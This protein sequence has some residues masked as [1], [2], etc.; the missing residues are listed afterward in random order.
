M[1]F[2]LL[3][4]LKQIKFP[5]R[6]LI[7]IIREIEIAP[8]YGVENLMSVWTP[9]HL[10]H[11]LHTQL[12]MVA[13][14]ESNR[15]VKACFEIAGWPVHNNNSRALSHHFQMVGKGDVVKPRCK[16]VYKLCMKS[17]SYPFFNFLHLSEI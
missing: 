1:K 16:S 4:R 9:K 7:Q 10:N 14:A 13:G 15:L 6:V 12:E 3:L 2:L 8:A 17:V 11:L 5:E